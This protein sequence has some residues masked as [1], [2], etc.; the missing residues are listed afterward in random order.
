M[1]MKMPKSP[2]IQQDPQL[3]VQQQQAQQQKMDEIQ[4]QVGADTDQLV[5]LFGA[6]NAFSGGSMQAPILGY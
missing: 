6:R 3:A 2:Q 4:K 1:A 5:R